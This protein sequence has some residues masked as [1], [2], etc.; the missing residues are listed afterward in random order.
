[1]RKNNW[2]RLAMAAPVAMTAL[3]AAAQIPA[4][5]YDALKGK[6]GA[7]LKTAIH[8]IIK[9]A[10]VLEY[11]SGANHTWWGFYV[12][13]NDSGYVVDR[14]SDNR[15][16]FQSRGSVPG[17]M[18]IEHSFPK[19]WWG[20]S[21]RQA[22]KDLFNLMPSDSKA[23]SSKGNYGMG[24]V[25][26]TGGKGYYDNGCIKVGAGSEG[27]KVWQPSDEW[28][29]DFS[30]GYM[31]MATAYQ[32]YT[33]TNDQAFN[34]LQ[35]GAYPT[36]KKWA[37]TLYIKWAKE[38]PVSKTE[39]D[40]NEA[41]YGIQ[42]NRNPYVDF[43]N[44]MEYVWGD[45]TNV[46]FNPE[47]TVKSGEYSGGGTVTPPDPSAGEVPVYDEDFTQDEG[48]CTVTYDKKPE[49][50]LEIW[51]I[52]DKYGWKANGYDSS[53]KTR[54][55]ADATLWLPELDLTDYSHATLT[56]SHAVNYCATPAD[57]LSVVAKTSR[58][59]TTLTGITWPAGSSWAFNESGKVSLNDFAGQKVTIG[60]RYTSTT[61]TAPCWEIKQAS[62]T[63]GGTNTG[64]SEHEAGAGKAHG[65]AWTTGGHRADSHYK[66]LVIKNGK[67]Y[68]NR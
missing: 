28:K 9:D 27:F 67:K 8:E 63:A 61:G 25:T 56:F 5:Y 19:S 22:Y 66:G 2:Q 15:V 20:G 30:R 55:D 44:L 60:F 13:D 32:D 68:L 59:A 53:T 24:I 62:V 46:P 29:G 38:D 39:T 36:L 58:G 7:E 57:Y 51:Q 16:K 11:G 1:M 18:N 33:W 40:R 35:Q 34:S 10:K 65:T 50:G 41:V 54:H 52:T 31:Y 45:S 64:I 3:T 43:P 14:Y 12:T 47:T 23:N 26:Q 49:S 37:Y 21:K 17:G 4:G 48:G 42:G 6:K